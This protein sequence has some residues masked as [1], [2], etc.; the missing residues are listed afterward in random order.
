MEGPSSSGSGLASPQRC[1]GRTAEI[2][3]DGRAARAGETPANAPGARPR[4]C[5]ALEGEPADG[6]HVARLAPASP[7]RSAVPGVV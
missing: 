6:R 7:D 3:G 1:D 4:D 5:R 2:G